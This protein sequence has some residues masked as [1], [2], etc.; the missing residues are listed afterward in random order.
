M[1]LVRCAAETEH[2]LP[3]LS[4][5]PS[6]G[7][8]GWFMTTEESAKVPAFSAHADSAG[9]LHSAALDQQLSPA[10]SQL[11]TPAKE[12]CARESVPEVLAPTSTLGTA[13]KDSGS[14]RIAQRKSPVSFS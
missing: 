8:N 11:G 1:A 13:P 2:E 6:S 7:P 9:C 4:K 3:R 10:G 12:K 5:M 14:D